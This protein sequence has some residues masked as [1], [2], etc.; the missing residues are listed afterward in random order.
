MLTQQVYSISFQYSMS[1][2]N[3]ESYDNIFHENGVIDLMVLFDKVYNG[4]LHLS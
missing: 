1:I 2:T 4:H 3:L